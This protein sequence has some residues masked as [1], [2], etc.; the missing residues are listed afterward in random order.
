MSRSAGI[1]IARSEATRRSRATAAPLRPLDRFAIADI[2]TADALAR[3]LALD[4]E[5]AKAQSPPG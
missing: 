5:R 3:L 2:A 4:L 1:V